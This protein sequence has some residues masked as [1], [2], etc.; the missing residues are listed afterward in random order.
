MKHYGWIPPIE[1]ESFNSKKL[2][3]YGHPK[4]YTIELEDHVFEQG[5]IGSCTSN[6]IVSAFAHHKKKVQKFIQDYFYITTKED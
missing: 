4:E 3:N 2:G 5:S 1:E 6:A